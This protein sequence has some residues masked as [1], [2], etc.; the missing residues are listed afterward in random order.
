MALRLKPKTY[1]PLAARLEAGRVTVETAP[2]QS[3]TIASPPVEDAA[4][5]VDFLV[6][7]VASC[8]AISLAAAAQGMKLD[9]GHIA[10]SAKAERALDLPS[11]V[12]GIEAV[13]TFEHKPQDEE[14]AR[15]LLRRGKEMCTVSNSLNAPV[16]LSL[17]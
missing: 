5:P 15:Q 14:T 12:A 4:S 17:A 9:V 3:V 2:A 16:A 13:V 6:A 11:R 8:L 10:V 7:A 1:G